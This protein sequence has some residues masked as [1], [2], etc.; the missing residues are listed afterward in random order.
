MQDT[1]LFKD[2]VFENERW[3]VDGLTFEHCT[4]RRCKIVF[5]ATEPVAFKECTFIECEWV[6]HGPAATTLDYVAALSHGLGAG[7]R[8]LVEGIFQSILDGS[9]GPEPVEVA[10]ALSPVGAR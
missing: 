1:L 8:E 3:E 6:F 10:H 5:S 9:F 2:R 4:F 7:G